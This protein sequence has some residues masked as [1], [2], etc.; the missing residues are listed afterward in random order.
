MEEVFPMLNWRVTPRRCG[1]IHRFAS[2]ETVPSSSSFH[3]KIYGTKKLETGITLS[4]EFPLKKNSKKHF[5]AKRFCR[6]LCGL[7]CC[8]TLLPL[9]GFLVAGRCLAKKNRLELTMHKANGGRISFRVPVGAWW[10]LFNDQCWVH[11][12]SSWWFR[13][14][15]IFYSLPGKMIQFD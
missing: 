6:R 1:D 11:S 12:Y 15:F 10:S 8:F 7:N 5:W 3:W 14:F 13:I 2:M 9:L 4:M